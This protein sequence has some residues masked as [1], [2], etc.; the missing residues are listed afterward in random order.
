[1]WIALQQPCAGLELFILRGFPRLFLLFLS[2]RWWKDDRREP[3]SLHSGFL[4]QHVPLML[5]TTKC[6][7]WSFLIV[8]SCF[9]PAGAQDLSASAVTSLNPFKRSVCSDHQGV[10]F[11]NLSAFI[12][13]EKEFWPLC[14][15]GALF[16]T[17]EIGIFLVFF[18][19]PI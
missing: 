6:I 8:C 14:T 15:M 5:F 16:S 3:T 1:M 18:F 11:A 19:L 7:Y 2:H 12:V 13:M 17:F 9:K 4:L 10:Y